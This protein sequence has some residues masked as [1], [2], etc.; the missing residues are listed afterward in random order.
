M[1][2]APDLL[3][4]QPVAGSTWLYALRRL[5]RG[6]KSGDLL[7]LAAA[8][9]LAVAATGSVGA[10]TERVRLALES[11]SGEALGGDARVRGREP[12]PEALRGELQGQGLRLSA[13]TTFPS[14]AIA[15]E[16]SSLVSVK[17]V[18]AG[19]PLRGELRLSEAPYAP[20]RPA[21]G[22]PPRGSVWVD[23]RALQELGLSVGQPLQL[24]RLSLTVAALIDFEPDR[25][26]GFSD[27][28][29]RLI[30]GQADLAEAGLLVEGSRASYQWLLAGPAEA[31]A[32]ARE[33]IEA[34]PELRYETPREA[35]QELA[36]ALDRAGLFL[37]VAGLAAALLAAA[38]VAL[39]A[40]AQGVALRNE[41]A[42]LKTLG[43]R[44]GFLLR[45]LSLQMLLLGLAAGGLGVLLAAA[46]QGV[47]AAALAGALE[48]ALPAPSPWPLLAAYALGLLLMLGFALP[49]LLEATATPPLRVLA[50]DLVPQPS[51]YVPL[52]ALAAV[53]VLLLVQTGAVDLALTVLVGAALAAGAL[54]GLAMAAVRLLAPLRRSVGAGLRFGL[55][56]V[57]RRQ[58]AT[59]GQVVALGLALLALLLVSVVREDLLETWRGRLPPEV[60]NQFLINIQNEQ[61][62]PLRAF[63]AARGVADAPLWPLA[64]ARLI[65]LNGVEV[66]EESFEDP[67]TRRWINREFN[68]S[69]TDRFGDDNQ[70]LSGD[71]WDE[72][73]RGQ[74]WVSA[75]DYAV[76]R[77]GL[78]LGDT[79]TLDFAGW[80]TTLTVVNTR[81]VSWDSFRP[82]FFLV[83]PPGAIEAAPRQWLTSFYLPP[84]QRGLLLELAREFP[85]I[86]ALD[87][88]AAL[89]QV[90]GII[91]R[92]VR[93]VEFVFLFALLAGLLVLMAAING[94]R[95][96]RRREAAVLRTLGART[97]TL[98]AGLLAEYATLGLLAGL[99]A[100]CAAQGIAWALAERAFEIPYGP[101]PLLWL[102]G[103]VSG[104]ALVTLLGWLSMRRVLSTPPRAI[105]G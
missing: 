21:S 92:V 99:V 89:N 101:R 57:A 44:R 97:A 56:N 19:Y 103:A 90:R 5:R 91:D 11:Q 33:R 35:R 32:I 72:A 82:N 74:P 86:T 10:F 29:P 59:V 51:R 2:R 98:R 37:D 52:L 69:W 96:E 71:W 4:L 70:L 41:V 38:A 34:D 1:Q 78:K 43:A 49:P 63:L 93:A 18:E 84:A 39:T 8:L 30:I 79:L 87:L 40:R 23:A 36:R 46:G 48:V 27:L 6:W 20:A 31:L 67:E 16:R 94:T 26:G 95:E 54:A 15:G 64:R 80:Q 66:S 105:L 88:E 104:T 102:I 47:I 77:L 65:G 53:A 81:K 12:L 28:G 73:A 68:L 55:G 62:E 13:V 45:G 14:V 85:N 3:P 17:A 58:A 22:A 76:E 42:L 100:A 83:T 9:A 75:E 61:V 60:P 50:R 25:G 24:G 7:I